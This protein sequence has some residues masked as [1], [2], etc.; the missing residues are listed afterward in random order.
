MENSEKFGDN[1]PS[2]TA[3]K[4]GLPGKKC[5]MLGRLKGDG[6]CP[7]FDNTGVGELN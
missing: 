2:M 5:V 6:M 1:R 4:Y 3:I 7:N